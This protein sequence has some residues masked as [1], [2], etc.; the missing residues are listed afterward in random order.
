VTGLS[1]RIG[2]ACLVH[3]FDLV[4]ESLGGN[5]RA[6]L[7]GGG[8]YHYCGSCNGC[9]VNTGDKGSRLRPH[10]A[11]ANGVG[12]ASAP[13]NKVA[14]IAP[15]SFSMTKI[16]Q[17]TGRKIVGTVETRELYT[18][19]KFW[20]SSEAIAWPNGLGKVS[21]KK[22]TSTCNYLDVPI[23]IMPQD[24]GFDGVVYLTL[25]GDQYHTFAIPK[26]YPPH[27]MRVLVPL[28]DGARQEMMKYLPWG[29]KP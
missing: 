10:P 24:A 9:P 20:I 5:Y 26:A 8:I 27:H 15:A 12:L 13:L 1:A 6:E 23:G 16:E 7:A 25:N 22:F 2:V 18:R 29:A 4:L 17:T 14:D 3:W 19:L 28:N 21:G 11:D